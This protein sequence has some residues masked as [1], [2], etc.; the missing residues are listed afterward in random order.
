[1]AKRT[2]KVSCISSNLWGFGLVANDSF[3]VPV[4]V[5]HGGSCYSYSYGV[6][7][8]GTRFLCYD[9]CTARH[10]QL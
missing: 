7:D 10:G 4:N 1:M 8:R 3:R 2:I 5:A 6:I 9:F